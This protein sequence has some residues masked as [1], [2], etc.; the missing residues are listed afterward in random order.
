MK[1]SIL[2]SLS[3][4]ITLSL[5]ATPTLA[6]EV[7][8]NDRA[9]TNSI[10][11]ITPS[12]LVTNAYQGFYAEQGIPS[13]GALITALDLGKVNAEDL[14]EKAITKGRLAPETIDDQRYLNSVDRLLYRLKTK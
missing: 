8:Q 2:F 3:A 4:A 12:N 9:M 14:V 1:T 6:K 10:V 5:V 7:S 11:E 13:Y